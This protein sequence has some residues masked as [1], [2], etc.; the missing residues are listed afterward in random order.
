MIFRMIKFDLIAQI[1]YWEYLEYIKKWCKCECK[2]KNIKE[3]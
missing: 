2:I 3:V 1:Y